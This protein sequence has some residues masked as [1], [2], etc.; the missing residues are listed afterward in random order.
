MRFCSLQINLISM[1]GQDIIFYG[2]RKLG[3]KRSRELDVVVE[4]I[5]PY[6]SWNVLQS[7]LKFWKASPEELYRN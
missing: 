6:I 7:L 2:L 4:N 5:W 1:A 3:E